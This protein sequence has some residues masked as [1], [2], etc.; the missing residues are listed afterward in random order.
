[1]DVINKELIYSI[2][3]I[4]IQ[5]KCFLR[6]YV[7]LI[8]IFPVSILQTAVTAN[9]SDISRDVSDVKKKWRDLSSQTKKREEERK[10]RVNGTGGGPSIEDDLNSW[11]QKACFN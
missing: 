4:L 6:M 8:L 1:M 7:Y 9:C 2:H 10:G 3:Y 11:E 5:S